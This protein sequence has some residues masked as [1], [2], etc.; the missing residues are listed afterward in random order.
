MSYRQDNQ[1]C[2]IDQIL[3]MEI[4]HPHANDTVAFCLV[5]PIIDGIEHIRDALTN[6][7]IR[8]LVAEQTIVALRS[9]GT[10]KQ[11]MVPVDIDG[12]DMSIGPATVDCAAPQT[13]MHVDWHESFVF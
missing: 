12:H 11:W 13:L 5:T 8:Q 4:G 9:L 10:R 3:T 7:P 1:Y 2:R 6:L